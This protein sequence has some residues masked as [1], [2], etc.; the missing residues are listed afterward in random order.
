M[1]SEKEVLAAL[2]KFEEKIKNLKLENERLKQENA[3]LK[4]QIEENNSTALKI[5]DLIDKI[6]KLYK[7]NEEQKNFLMQSLTKNKESVNTDL[8]VDSMMT[9]I[10]ENDAATSE[11][12]D[13]INE[14]KSERFTQKYEWGRASKRTLNLFIDFINSLW[15]NAPR[16]NNI[17]VL[18]SLEQSKGI[19]DDES[20]NTFM[21]YL[22][23]KGFVIKRN[24]ELVSQ[25]T[26]EIVLKSIE[27]VIE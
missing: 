21:N 8:N 20:L 24:D 3:D 2:N 1:I 4:K 22:Y 15:Y 14:I 9:K 25:Y 13:K 6:D 12:D 7:N 11:V 27:K 17:F 19:L 18:K 23:K 16:V 26:K 10:K 5:N